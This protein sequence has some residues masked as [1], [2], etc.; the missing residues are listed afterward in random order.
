M[1][2]LTVSCFKDLLERV[3]SVAFISTTN[4]QTGKEL[5][6]RFTARAFRKLLSIYI[7]SYFPFLF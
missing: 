7:F 1:G 2:L 4:K 6:I 5:F 3:C